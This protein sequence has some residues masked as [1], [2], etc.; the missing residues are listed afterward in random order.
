MSA[1]W[2]GVHDV[3]E[4]KEKLNTLEANLSTA[5]NG[6]ALGYKVIATGLCT[7]TSMH[8]DKQISHARMYARK[9]ENKAR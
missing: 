6:M 2:F 1:P 3:Q 8:A 7:L 4:L 5:R 9:K